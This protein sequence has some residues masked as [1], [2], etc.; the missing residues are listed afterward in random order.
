M[1]VSL[2]A[3]GAAGPRL[4]LVW[5]WCGFGVARRSIGRRHGCKNSGR[6]CARTGLVRVVGG[7]ERSAGKGGCR[8]VGPFVG[9]DRSDSSGLGKGPKLP[10]TR[11]SRAR[12]NQF[13]A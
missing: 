5:F 9:R 4:V 1:Q 10:G 8:W 13:G 6:D 3:R 7:D 11:G 2:V 12:T